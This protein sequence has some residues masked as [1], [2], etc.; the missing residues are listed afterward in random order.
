MASWKDGAAYAPTERP[1]GFATPRVEPLPS[2]DQWKSA[3]P[4]PIAAPSGFEA[5]PQAPLAQLSSG[6]KQARDPKDSFAVSASA[7]TPGPGVAVKRN[8][9]DPIVTSAPQPVGREWASAMG[10]QLPPPTGPR[11]PPPGDLVPAPPQAAAPQPPGQVTPR[12]AQSPAQYPVPTPT[13][14]PTPRGYP[15][16]P[17]V[18]QPQRL[19]AAQKQLAL[20][21]GGLCFL[22]FVLPSLSPFVLTAAGALGMRTEALTGRAG[23]SALA[24]GLATLGW[25]FLM[26]TLGRDSLVGM[27]ASLVFTI[28]F[29]VGAL[30]G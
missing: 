7:L 6:P 19:P 30:R 1:E 8:P 4:G 29:V 10:D 15:P 16:P 12:R 21:A 13:G 3:T 11:L 28:V 5:A 22:G 2:G 9:R 27:F 14:Y 20:I 26:D 24:I 17:P 23:R 18:G 25:Q